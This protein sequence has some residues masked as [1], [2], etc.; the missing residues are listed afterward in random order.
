VLGSH[1]YVACSSAGLR[2]LD[3]STP[4]SPMEIANIATTGAALDVAVEGERAYVAVGS[5]GFDIF[6]VSNPGARS[7]V[8][9]R[10]DEP[11]HD[12]AVTGARVL[13]TAGSVLRVAGRA[14]VVPTALR[15]PPG[16][17]QCSR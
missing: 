2:I 13:T 12:I 6:D 1:L 16:N 7:N 15:L 3:V 17:W 5:A 11:A 10:S 14:L 9:G 8:G 4:S